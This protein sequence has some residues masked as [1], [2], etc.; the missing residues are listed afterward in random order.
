MLALNE[1]VQKIEESAMLSASKIVTI[2]K[3]MFGE[4]GMR[5]SGGSSD[6][7]FRSVRKGRSHTEIIR[8]WFGDEDKQMKENVNKFLKDGLK[9]NM[10]DVDA[11]FGVYP[12]ESSSKYPSLKITAKT[13]I[14]S[15][16]HNFELKK[17][18]S[19]Y[20]VCKGGKV[21][22]KEFTPKSLG[23]GNKTFDSIDSIVDTIKNTK[24]LEGKESI[25]ALMLS[26][27]DLFTKEYSGKKYKTF[28]EL[29]EQKE[30][31]RDLSS[32]DIEQL[33][34]D[35]YG[36]L[37]NDFGEV[38]GPCFILS[39]LEGKHNVFFPSESNNAMYDYAIDYKDTAKQADVS[40][41]KDK[42]AK[43]SSFDLAKTII[44]LGK[45][46]GGKLDFV[47][48]FLLNKVFPILARSYKGMKLSVVTTKFALMT[49]L[50]NEVNDKGAKSILNCLDKYGVEI[51]DKTY[52]LNVDTINKVKEDG[53]LVE[54]LSEVNKLTGYMQASKRKD[55][56]TPEVVERE[57]DSNNAKNIRVGCLAQPFQK[58]VVTFLNKNFSDQLN[59]C[60]KNSFGGW[61][62]YTDTKTKGKAKINIVPMN[63][64]V[65]YA[66]G[67]EGSIKDP[68]LKSIS[69]SIVKH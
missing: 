27:I 10:D 25:R 45:A 60:A 43:P 12:D 30:F 63:G 44:E 66:L 31:I 13:D 47:D 35:S 42:G 38:L 20:V 62:L 26:M 41:K 2:Y 46:N 32:S 50:A 11:E 65:T 14:S 39:K 21:K 67:E 55:T 40:A 6:N 34:N 61:Q 15:N 59:A 18:E 52:S 37:M 16:D 24:A 56:Y 23:L 48:G 8:A 3:G 64:D 22:K 5:K 33:D 51:D 58:Y 29:A 36:S 54:F 1:Y 57:W 68:G 4:E 9:I 69:I 17:G 7:S 28:T 49:L 19:A 53:K